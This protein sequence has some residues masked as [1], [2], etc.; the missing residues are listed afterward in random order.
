MVASNLPGVRTVVEH[1]SDGLLA[2]PGSAAS[3]AGAIGW[4]LRHEA[5][6]RVMGLHGRAKVESRYDWRQI[7]RRLERIYGRALAE[8]G[9]QPVL[10]LEAP[11][12][13]ATRR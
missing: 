13:V 10:H 12:R 11:R 8:H 2:E 1:G 4:V 6:R 3:L 9:T 7:G 5:K